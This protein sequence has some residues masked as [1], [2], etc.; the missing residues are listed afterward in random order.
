[1]RWDGPQHHSTGDQISKMCYLATTSKLV[2]H[3]VPIMEPPQQAIP[4]EPKCSD[5]MENCRKVTAL[6]DWPF[7]ALERLPIGDKVR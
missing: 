7:N 1:M 6:A 3:F 5:L 4:P 2:D